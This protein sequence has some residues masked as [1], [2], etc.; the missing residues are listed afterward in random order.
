MKQE[1]KSTLARQRILTAAI[2]EFSEKGYEGASLSAACA[3][4]GISKGIVYH[5]FKDKNELYLLCVKTCFESLTTYLKT[6]LQAYSGPDEGR[7]QYY[8]AARLRFFAQQPQY[9]GI[10]TGAV[11]QPPEALSAEI[12]ACRKEFDTLNLSALTSLLE[13]R[14][15]RANLTAA[16]ITEDFRMYMDDFNLHFREALRQGASPEQVLR[17][18]E[19]RCHRLIDILLHG[20]L[21]V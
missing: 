2:A 13:G 17:E 19:E 20:I 6:A 9:L 3:Q 11:F 15:L 5:H 1:A 14:K 7:M 21:D 10:F 4:N 16:M 12:A 18:H 8:F